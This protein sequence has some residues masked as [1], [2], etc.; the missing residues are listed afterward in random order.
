MTEFLYNLKI[1][2]PIKLVLTVLLALK[3]NS[4]SCTKVS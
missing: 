3:H 2:V 4:K 1:S